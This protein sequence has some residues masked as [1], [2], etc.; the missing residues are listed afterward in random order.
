MKFQKAEIH[1]GVFL[2]VVVLLFQCH[3][4]F[5]QIFIDKHCLLS[6][7]YFEKTFLEFLRISFIDRLSK[8]DNVKTI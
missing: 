2:E 3:N 1:G 4:S 5:K 6:K 7:F 8:F